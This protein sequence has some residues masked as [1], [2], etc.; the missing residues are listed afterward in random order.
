M[1]LFPLEWPTDATKQSAVVSDTQRFQTNNVFPPSSTLFAVSYCP[2]ILFTFEEQSALREKRI[3][4]LEVHNL[5]T[6]GH[7][8]QMMLSRGVGCCGN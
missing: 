3:L 5:K 6:M 4:S 7:Y 1:S 8:V 2:G